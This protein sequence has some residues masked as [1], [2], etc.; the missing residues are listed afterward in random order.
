M[1]GGRRKKMHAGGT[2]RAKSITA[3]SW[4]SQKQIISNQVLRWAH[5]MKDNLRF[6]LKN[7]AD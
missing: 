2:Q 7:T 6:G 5:F 1:K 4:H 3:Y